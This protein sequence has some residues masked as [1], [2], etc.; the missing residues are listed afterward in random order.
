MWLRARTQVD[1]AGF[2][3]VR[4]P[5]DLTE[6]ADIVG[7]E[8]E[9]WLNSRSTKV[10]AGYN[11]GSEPERLIAAGEYRAA[12]IAAIAMLEDRLKTYILDVDPSESVRRSYSL[13]DLVRWAAGRRLIRGSTD[14]EILLKSIKLR[15]SALHQDAHV[16]ERQAVDAAR[17]ITHVIN[18]MEEA[19]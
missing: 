13:T 12:L 8:V 17:V 2:D 3:V 9:R 7:V 18:R 6:A 4:R 19:S 1:A 15:N 14:Q 11:E 10:K 5:E 16:T